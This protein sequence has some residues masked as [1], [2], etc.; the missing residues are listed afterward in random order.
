MPPEFPPVRVA[1]AVLALAV[2]AGVLV[3]PV[4]EFLFVDFPF[5]AAHLI[6]DRGAAIEGYV[7]ASDFVHAVETRGLVR[8][9]ELAVCAHALGL[10]PSF[11]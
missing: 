6:R 2:G 3:S 11:L 8:Q 4:V 7:P 9:I 1:F 5:A 10:L